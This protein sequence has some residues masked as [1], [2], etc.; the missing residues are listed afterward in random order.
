MVLC[1]GFALYDFLAPA[2]SSVVIHFCLI[3]LSHLQEFKSNHLMGSTR[4]YFFPL[5]Y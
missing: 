5:Y 1:V 3:A 2:F 4:Y